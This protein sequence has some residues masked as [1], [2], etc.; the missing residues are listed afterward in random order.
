MAIRLGDEAPNFTAQTTDGR[1]E[2]LRLF[3]RQL[4]RFIFSSEG[5]HAGLHNRTRNGGANETRIR[6]TQC[7]NYRFE[8]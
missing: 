2:F 3:R 1:I 8:R 7:Q 6:Q 5:L 4:G